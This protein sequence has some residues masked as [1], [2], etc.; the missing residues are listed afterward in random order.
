LIFQQVRGNNALDKRLHCVLQFHG[1]CLLASIQLR[2]VAAFM[3]LL[4]LQL[5][6]N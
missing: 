2:E 6:C 3:R 5:I 4:Q 1:G